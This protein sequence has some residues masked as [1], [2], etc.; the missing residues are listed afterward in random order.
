M[1]DRPPTEHATSREEQAWRQ[2]CRWLWY[3]GRWRDKTPSR[4]RPAPCAAP[5]VESRWTGRGHVTMTSSKASFSAFSAPPAQRQLMRW[6]QSS[7]RSSLFAR[8]S[9]LFALHGIVLDVARRTTTSSWVAAWSSASE[10]PLGA[11]ALGF[12]TGT[13]V[14]LGHAVP[15]TTREPRRLV[16]VRFGGH[17][18]G[19]RVEGDMRPRE[20]SISNNG[21]DS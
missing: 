7:C 9:W 20:G 3:V 21:H 14:P 4:E 2:T 11:A 15:S 10:E 13:F 5:R 16:I 12:V 18:L 1:A 19:G 8:R 17:L 6:R